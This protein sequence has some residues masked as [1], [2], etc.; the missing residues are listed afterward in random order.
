VASLAV[1]CVLSRHVA[2]LLCHHSESLVGDLWPLGFVRD[3]ESLAMM[4]E[5]S[6]FLSSATGAMVRDETKEAAR[7]TGRRRESGGA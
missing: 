4:V 3:F 1:L 2:H 5:C 6:H 7:A